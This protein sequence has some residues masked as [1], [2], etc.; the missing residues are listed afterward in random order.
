M[1]TIYL[2]RLCSATGQAPDAP[3]TEAGDRQAL[4]LADFFQNIPINRIISSDYTRAIAS[5][6]PLAV[7][8]QL[9]IETEP[10]LRERI[11][12]L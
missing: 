8:K 1:S 11:L 12:S 9:T 7:S 2:I 10:K 4:A 5:I 6:A 3:L